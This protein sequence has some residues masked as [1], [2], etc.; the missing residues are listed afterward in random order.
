MKVLIA[1]LV[2]AIAIPLAGSANAEIKTIRDSEGRVFITGLAP[3]SSNDIVFPDV[4]FAKEFKANSCGLVYISRKLVDPVNKPF[5]FS[6]RDGSDPTTYSFPS[7]TFFVKRKPDC[8]NG[9]LSDPTVS[10]ELTEFFKIDNGDF[11]IAKLIPSQLYMVFYPKALI[12]KAKANACGIVKLTDS[13]KYP[14]GGQLRVNGQTFSPNELPVEIPPLCRDGISYFPTAITNNV[15]VNKNLEGNLLISNLPLNSATNVIF[16]GTPV[17][18]TVLSDSCGFL[19][20]K[21]SLSKPLPRQVEVLLNNQTIISKYNVDFISVD[22]FPKPKCENGIIQWT[23]FYQGNF[24]LPNGDYVFINL[25][26]NTAYQAEYD[27]QTVKSVKANAC[28]IGNIKRTST[29]QPL[30]NFS[31]DG[32]GS[33]ISYGNLEPTNI[34][35]FCKDGVLYA[36]KEVEIFIPF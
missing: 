1:V 19:V 21:N 33:G 31:I 34:K 13:V 16:D 9:T 25:Q 14:L 17:R 27:L 36:P 10:T 26:P 28:G 4:N 2:G 24:K 22:S 23:T 20:V 11:M 32:G 29:F 7:N 18:K 5:I 8:F 30:G 6:K 3:N 12:R 35:K 15:T